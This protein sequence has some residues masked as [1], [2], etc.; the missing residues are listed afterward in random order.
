MLLQ[1]N[2]SAQT[3]KPYTVSAG[4]PTFDN[5][6][7]LFMQQNGDQIWYEWP[8]KIYG[9]SGFTNLRPQVVGVDC[10]NN[11][12]TCFSV[13]K[14]Y[15]ISSDGITWPGSWTEMTPEN[16]SAETV[17]ATNGFYLRLR[18]TQRYCVKYDTETNN[19]LV[20]GFTGLEGSVATFAS[21]GTGTI[22]ASEKEGRTGTLVLSGA[23]GA[24]ANNDTIQV[25]AV[26]MALVNDATAT[27]FPR[28][29]SNIS[30]LMIFTERNDAV[31]DYPVGTVNIVLKNVVT[32]SRYY[33]YD[34][35]NSRLIAEGTSPGGDI[36]IPAAYDFDGSTISILTRVRKSTAAPKYIPFEVAGSYN[37]NGA[38][39]YVSQVLDSFA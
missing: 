26:T 6:G 21:G 17:S 32:G 4:N 5:N 28:N 33:V 25:A 16:L 27:F 1:F 35:T 23:A 8:Y 37:Q 3:V 12:N 30:G 36:T 22:V 14:E 24:I 38:I 11:V 15:K 9:V 7:A 19:G 20:W 18:F 39:V 10:G 34:T 2:A 29:T 31:P 13:L